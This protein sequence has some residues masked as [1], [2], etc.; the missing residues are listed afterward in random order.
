MLVFYAAGG[1]IRELPGDAP[2]EA[3]PHDVIWI[4]LLQATA[5][6]TAFVERATGLRIPSFENLSEI[7]ASSRLRTD[8]GVL[9]LSAPLVSGADGDDPRSTPVGLILSPERLITIRFEPLAAFEKVREIKE[10]TA[11]G[12]F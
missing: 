5:I 9:Y 12:A 8:R 6:E 2:P 1:D 3:L 11:A 7:E 4:D 10:T